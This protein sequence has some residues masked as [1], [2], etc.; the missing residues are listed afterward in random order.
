MGDLGCGWGGLKNKAPKASDLMKVW[1]SCRSQILPHPEVVPQTPPPPL[2]HGP[3]GLPN[4]DAYVYVCGYAHAYVY[5]CGYAHAYVHSYVL[6]THLYVYLWCS[7]PS[8]S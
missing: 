8:M 5:V 2:K 7:A 6:Y 3:Y 1:P 4:V